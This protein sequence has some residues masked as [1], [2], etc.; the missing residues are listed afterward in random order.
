MCSD[1]CCCS[2]NNS[3]SRNRCHDCSSSC[4]TSYCTTIDNSCSR[5]S[6]CDNSELFKMKKANGLLRNIIHKLD[7]MSDSIRLNKDHYRCS[8]HCRN[9]LSFEY[10]CN[11]CQVARNTRTFDQNNNYNNSYIL[12]SDCESEISRLHAN[13]RYPY[14][15]YDD[16]VYPLSQR[17]YRTGPS[18]YN[19]RDDDEDE[20][21]VS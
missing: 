13:I 15:Q 9:H 16:R 6:C 17:H 7:S 5:S 18:Y 14:S 3:C 11:I 12:C 10:D 21:N 4:S 20:D 8:C 2:C 1:Q 19:Y